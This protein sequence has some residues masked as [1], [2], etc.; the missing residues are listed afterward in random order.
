MARG[1]RH[2]LID[3]KRTPAKSTEENAKKMNNRIKANTELIRKY[4][5][6]LKKGE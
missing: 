2:G 6:E 5:A 4:Q 3:P 1:R